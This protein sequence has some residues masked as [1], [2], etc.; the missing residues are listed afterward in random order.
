MNWRL[1]SIL[2]LLAIVLAAA[3]ILGFVQSHE[4]LLWLIVGAYCAWQFAGKVNDDFFLH[5]FYL[6][7]LDGILN[8]TAKAIFFDS[9]LSK[10]PRMVEEFRSLPQDLSPQMVLLI[11]GPIIGAFSGVA[12]GVLAVLASKVRRKKISPDSQ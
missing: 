5:G 6:G 9:Y 11:M 12:F 1:I 4:W 2:S 10:N 7:I 8:S 3:S